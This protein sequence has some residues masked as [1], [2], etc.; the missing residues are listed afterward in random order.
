MKKI[1]ILTGL[2]VL[3]SV[4]V[5]AGGGQQP[6]TK[7]VAVGPDD[8]PLTPYRE[9]LTINIMR[10]N[11]T[12]V[13][14]PEGESYKDNILT[15]F[16]KEKLNIVY[17]VKWSA[18]RGT[19]GTQLDLAIAANDLPDM[20]E[21]NSSQVYRLAVA[22]QIEPLTKYYDRYVV[23]PVKADYEYA[24]K[25]YLSQ[26]T[27]NGE[28]YAVPCSDDLAGGSDGIPILLFRQDWLDK[29]GLKAPTTKQEFL[30]V[31][32]AFVNRDP[33][34]NGQKDTWA[35][36]VGNNL[37]FAFTNISNVFGHYP[38]KWDV[39]DGKLAWNDIQPSVLKPLDFLRDMYKKGYIDPQFAVKDLWTKVSED[40]AAGKIGIV[41]GVFW[42][43][44]WGG[45]VG[46]K[47]ANPAAEWTPHSILLNDQGKLNT[48]SADIN[49]DRYIVVKK[50]FPNPE[51]AFKQQN[52]WRELWRGQYAEFYH[53]NNQ[54]RYNKA[55]EDFKTYPPFW[56]DPATKNY[57]VSL[58]QRYA[59]EHGKDL[60]LVKD[61]EGIKH[62]KNFLETLEGKSPSLN[63]WAEMIIRLNLWPVIEKQYG[64]K[65]P[66]RYHYTM[67]KGPIDRVISEKKPLADKV[68]I[69][70]LTKYIM[71]ET[72]DFQGY[73]KDWLNAGG[74][75][76]T[77][78]VNVWYSANKK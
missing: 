3:G 48:V 20:F 76:W 71:G 66:A 78:D 38:N 70:F 40:V 19:M 53:G 1:L 62:F 5:F 69:E 17:N 15:R 18:E 47:K 13:W 74:Q 21:V 75:D 11:N 54:A 33:D 6:A 61:Q 63:G 41:P 16:Y 51:A 60:S 42:T 50:G 39:Y 55:M 2:M 22:G 73:V 57:D 43:P 8:G 67:Y 14:Y 7:G 31:C 77:N 56:Y 37:D 65:D 32:D 4:L 12:D 24:D 28:M 23:G 35:F 72:D 44:I 36:A 10:E 46:S 59:W 58:E 49:C 30:A 25:V 64:G 68:R 34:G 9:P 27:V 26:T 52:L 45:I 29:L